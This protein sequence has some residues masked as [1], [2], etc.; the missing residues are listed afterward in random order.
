MLKFIQA[1]TGLTPHREY[2]S[3]TGHRGNGVVDGVVPRRIPLRDEDLFS[4][5]TRSPYWAMLK[6]TDTGTALPWL[7]RRGPVMQFFPAD[8]DARCVISLN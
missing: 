4:F 8:T 7:F 2:G 5:E 3:P 6:A 1:G